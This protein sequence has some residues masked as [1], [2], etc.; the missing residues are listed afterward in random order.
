MPSIRLLVPVGSV[1]AAYIL[2]PANKCCGETTD[3]ENNVEE[4]LCM[5]RPVLFWC[6]VQIRAFLVPM[7]LQFFMVVFFCCF[8]YSM[9]VLSV[10]HIHF[11]VFNDC[12]M[13]GILFFIFKKGH[14]SECHLCMIRCISAVQNFSWRSSNF[15]TQNWIVYALLR[16]KCVFTTST[17]E[18]IPISLHSSCCEIV[19]SPEDLFSFSPQ[20]LIVF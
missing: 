10:C 20:A 16:W 11:S 13:C 3:W 14:R 2:V 4:R 17:N 18:S 15:T 8:G 19:L 12:A 7:Q 9:F 6:F 5:V 1:S